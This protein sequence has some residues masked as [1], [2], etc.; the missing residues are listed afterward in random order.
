M[1]LKVHHIL[2][3]GTPFTTILELI[4]SIFRGKALWERS[5]Q[6]GHGI[7]LPTVLGGAVLCPS[8]HINSVEAI[9]VQILGSQIFFCLKF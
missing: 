2:S 4:T 6:C 8:K 7:S 5:S 9:K 3:M 1:L